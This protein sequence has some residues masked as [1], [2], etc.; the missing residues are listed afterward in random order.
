MGRSSTSSTKGK[1]KA[2]KKTT[3]VKANKVVYCSKVIASILDKLIEN[4]LDKVKKHP[5][6]VGKW[7]AK[8]RSS[9]LK[10]ISTATPI[11]FKTEK[12]DMKALDDMLSTNLKK[13]DATKAQI[14][15]SS[16]KM[17]QDNFEK[18]Q[19]QLKQDAAKNKRGGAKKVKENNIFTDRVNIVNQNIDQMANQLSSIG[20]DIENRV[21]SLSTSIQAAEKLWSANP[22][23]GER[24]GSSV[25]P[26]Y[27]PCHF[28]KSNVYSPC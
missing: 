22:M 12:H 2:S 21:S 23:R 24:A 18:M 11:L 20:K 7:M 5:K 25:V 3:S 1:G 26:R 9:I 28:L 6:T 8:M 4:E 19:K 16:R 10:K 14:V 15:E 13:I 17:W 27:L